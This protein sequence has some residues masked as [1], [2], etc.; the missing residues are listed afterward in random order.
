MRDAGRGVRVEHEGGEV[1]HFPGE[2]NVGYIAA[3]SVTGVRPPVV[4]PDGRRIR[5]SP[6]AITRASL[7]GRLAPF[8]T[9]HTGFLDASGRA[10]ARIDVSRFPRLS[11]VTVWIQ[12]ATLGVNG[13]AT[14]ADPVRLTF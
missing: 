9:G 7:A 6:D 2:A 1:I 8:F 14:A 5:F 10:I 3:L 11:G 13:F 12:A 4:L